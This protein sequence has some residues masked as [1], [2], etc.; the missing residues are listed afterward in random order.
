MIV[1]IDYGMGNTGSVKNA[2][3]FLGAD[4]LVSNNR[5]DVKM[6]SHLIL[7]GVGS[8]GDGISNLKESG[9]ANILEEEVLRGRK[10]L[11]GICLGMQLLAD[12]GDEGGVNKGLGW[13]HGRTVKIRAGINK[14][15]HI[16]WNNIKVK[17]DNKILDN[18]A[19]NVFYFVHSYYL[20]PDAEKCVLATSE[21]GEEF[22][23]VVN[24][25]NIW[26]VQFHPE[27]SQKSGLQFLKN[28]LKQR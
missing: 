5:D 17:S 11:L 22:P 2:L 18:I 19:S 28:F 15:P 23:V 27:K 4:V 16:G 21:Y 3:E 8:F 13:I 9:L 6:S 1:I 24:K 26:G 14:L 12:E 10:P 20:Q 7:P 25:D